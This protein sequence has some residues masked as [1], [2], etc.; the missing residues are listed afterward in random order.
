MPSRGGGIKNCRRLKAT[1]AFRKERRKGQK[2]VSLE[3]RKGQVPCG[4]GSSYALD[5]PIGRGIPHTTRRFA[6]RKRL[7]NTRSTIQGKFS[8]PPEERNIESPPRKISTRPWTEEK[9]FSGSIF[10]RGRWR[11]TFKKSKKEVSKG[12]AFHWQST[13]FVLIHFTFNLH[14]PYRGKIRGEK[15]CWFSPVEKKGKER[16]EG[17]SPHVTL[18][19]KKKIGEKG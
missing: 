6:K 10:E 19:R 12:E 1:A 13:R 11:R 9:F 3:F 18:F 17:T 8:Y 15:K 4:G 2:M 14:L 5:T 16:S 7:Q